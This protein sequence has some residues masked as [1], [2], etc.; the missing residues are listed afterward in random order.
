MTSFIVRGEE[1]L[2]SKAKEAV[3][4]I[5][6]IFSHDVEPAIEAF[7]SQFITDFGKKVLADAEALAPQVASGQVSIVEAGT[8]LL[9]QAAAQAG[10]IAANDAVTVALNALRVQITALN[11]PNTVSKAGATPPVIP[12]T[13]VADATV[14]AQ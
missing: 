1:Y 3:S 7:V 2:V 4:G 6:S 11:P 14:A 5:A 12:A 10:G 9:A 13:P 8:Q